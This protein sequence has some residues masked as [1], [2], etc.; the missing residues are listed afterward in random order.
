MTTD[1][2]DLKNYLSDAFDACLERGMQLPFIVCAAS[3]NGSVLCMRVNGNGID[4]YILAQHFEPPGFRI[5]ITCMVLD[6]SGEAA[7]LNITKHGVMF[8]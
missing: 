8:H 3:P 7:R 5:P 4:G 1:E 6:Q 2:M